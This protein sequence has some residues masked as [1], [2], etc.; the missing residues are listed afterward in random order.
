MRAYTFPLPAVAQERR[1]AELESDLWEQAADGGQGLDAALRLV[2]GVPDDVLW[3]LRRC[4]EA[5]HPVRNPRAVMALAVPL[6]LALW[7]IAILGHR[8]GGTVEV[9]GTG[10]YWLFFVAALSAV[11]TAMWWLLSRVPT[12][13]KERAR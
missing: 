8:R 11:A 10:A 13:R 9:V 6:L 2:R 5:A 12:R 7:A 4:F 1:R 3:S